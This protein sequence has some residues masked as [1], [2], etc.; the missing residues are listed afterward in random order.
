MTRRI[1]AV[2]A[3]THASTCD[4]SLTQRAM[5]GTAFSLHCNT[6]LGGATILTCAAQPWVYCRVKSRA[7]LFNCSS[8][9][10]NLWGHK[11]PDGKPMRP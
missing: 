11:G 9:L 8:A 10:V 2:H 7:R 1:R 5:E 4:A 3:Y 6:K